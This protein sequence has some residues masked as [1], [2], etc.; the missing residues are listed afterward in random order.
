MLLAVL[1]GAHLLLGSLDVHLVAVH[2]HFP[3]LFLKRE[4]KGGRWKKGNAVAVAGM[5]SRTA[6][7][8]GRERRRAGLNFLGGG[9]LRISFCPTK[10]KCQPRQLNKGKHH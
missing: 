2:L 3:L 7:V 9:R 5:Q 4:N 10:S 6:E 1:H 8:G